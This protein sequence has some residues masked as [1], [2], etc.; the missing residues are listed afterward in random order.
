[1][2][3]LPARA[4]IAGTGAITAVGYCVPQIWA[5]VRAGVSLYSALG[6]LDASFDKIRMAVVDEAD[7]EPLVPEIDDMVFPNRCRR[8]IRLAAPAVREAMAGL[9][10]PSA[11]PLFLGLPAPLGAQKPD[12]FLVPAIAHQAGVKLDVSASQTFLVGRAAFFLALEKAL[13]SMEDRRMHSVLVGAVDSYL[14]PVVLA[15]LDREGRLLSDQVADGL[16]PGE[17]AGF[18]L[19]TRQAPPRSRSS[20]VAGVG[21]AKDSG[22]RYAQSPARGEGLWG[23]MNGLL[24]SARMGDVKISSTFAGLNGE[25]FG[26]REWGVARLRHKDRFAES[27]RLDHPADCYGDIG[28]ASGAVL[29]ALAVAALTSGHRQG[30]ALVWASSDH[31]ERGCVLIDT[32]TVT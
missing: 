26:A 31:E 17:G 32:A 10:L 14:D 9:A 2:S 18:I 24:Q 19:L 28:A 4:V 7:L 23:A 12:P 1:M 20:F 11:P 16:I 8:M 21:V 27:S 25:S 3:K 5:S 15:R 6:Q 22:H 13:Q 30:P 29:T